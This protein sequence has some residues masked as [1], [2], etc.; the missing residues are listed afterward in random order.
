MVHWGVRDGA[1]PDRR[2]DVDEILFRFTKRG[3]HV[4]E[5]HPFIL[6]KPVFEDLN[7]GAQMDGISESFKNVAVQ[8]NYR[9]LM[10][11]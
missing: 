6:G 3:Y 7:G 1:E 8:V 5:N 2:M 10:G 9:I 11:Q 4:A